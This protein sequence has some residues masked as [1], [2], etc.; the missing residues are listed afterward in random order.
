MTSFKFSPNPDQQLHVT[1]RFF[2]TNDRIIQVLSFLAT[3]L[4]IYD[5]GYVEN[6][7]LDDL[8]YLY[9]VFVFCLGVGYT[10]R[11]YSKSFYLRT[12]QVLFELIVAILL[13]VVAIANLGAVFW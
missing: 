5:I 10:L 13:V 8:F 9:T 7:P 2:A 1:K 4:L 11:V 12:S 3:A 6:E